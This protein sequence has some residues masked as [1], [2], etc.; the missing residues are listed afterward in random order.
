MLWFFERDRESLQIETRYD[1]D[2][3]EFVAIV[4]HPDG[5]EDIARFAELGAFRSYLAAVQQS[6][7]ESRWVSCGQP[8]ILPDGW[9]KH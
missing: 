2:T 8:I 1:S 5:R 9:R 3:S 4:R 7:D 6:V